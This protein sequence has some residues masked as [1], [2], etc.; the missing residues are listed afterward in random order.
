MR[1]ENRD[2]QTPQID[3]RFCGHEM[4]PCTLACGL[5]YAPAIANAISSVIT[6]PAATATT[7]AMRHA[8]SSRRDMFGIST[9]AANDIN[10]SLLIRES[11]M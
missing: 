7:L 6:R 9:V 1:A 11:S 5:V 2:G 4:P 8:C 10:R 3:G